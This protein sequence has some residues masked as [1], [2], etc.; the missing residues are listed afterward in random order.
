MM[1]PPIDICVLCER[2]EDL[3]KN[4]IGYKGLKSMKRASKM[5]GEDDLHKKFA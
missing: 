5:K 2:N 3:L 1:K 4:V